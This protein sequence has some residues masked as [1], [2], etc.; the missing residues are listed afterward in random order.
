MKNNPTN[1]HTLT[2]LVSSALCL[3]TMATIKLD[4][5]HKTK[6]CFSHWDWDFLPAYAQENFLLQFGTSDD[7]SED[8]KS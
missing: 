1:G 7:L 2:D 3:A 4:A 5:V 8:D 6:L